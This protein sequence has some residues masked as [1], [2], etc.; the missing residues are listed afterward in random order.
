M[1]I[2]FKGTV[3]ECKFGKLFP[4][5][6]YDIPEKMFDA[7]VMDKVSEPV[8]KKQITRTKVEPS[9]LETTLKG[10]TTKNKRHEKNKKNKFGRFVN[11]ISKNKKKRIK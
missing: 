11:K 6:I 9:T 2:L 1:K 4:G 3:T 10:K 5:K 7:S 8:V